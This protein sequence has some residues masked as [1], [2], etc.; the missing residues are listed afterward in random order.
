MTQ[1]KTPGVYVE[2]KNAFGSS[3]VANETAIPIFFG[4]TEKAQ[5]TNGD[6]IPAVTSADGGDEVSMPVLVDSILTYQEH[7]GGEDKTGTMKVTEDNGEF[8]AEI[9]KGTT[10][11][12]PS[13]MYPSISNFFANGGGKCYI[14]SLGN[15]DSFNDIAAIPDMGLFKEAIEYAETA[16][17]I[18]IPD[19]I[20]FGEAKYYDRC[21]ALLNYLEESKRQFLIMDVIQN[22]D[23]NIYS[24]NDAIAFRE[25]VSGAVR[26]GAGYF[27]YLKSLT[28]YAYDKDTTTFNGTLLSVL[29]INGYSYSGEYKNNDEDEIP[30]LVAKYNNKSPTTTPKLTVKGGAT[31]ESS[32]TATGEDKNEVVVTVGTN[33]MTPDD[34]QRKWIK[35]QEGWQLTCLADIT[36]PENEK[37]GTFNEDD[38]WITESDASF[39][40]ILK[41]SGG[42]PKNSTVSANIAAG[43]AFSVAEAN[44]NT[45]T[46]TIETAD[47]NKITAEQ[48]LNKVNTF[49]GQ[50]GN[51]SAAED[52]QFA[53][54]SKFTGQVKGGETATL[55]RV[56]A[57]D[58]ATV[59]KVENFLAQNYIDMPP[60]PFMA[61]IYSR[62]DN[63]QGVWIAPAN[64]SPVGVTA[65]L[66]DITRNQQEGLN[67]DASSGKSI[68]AIR[69]FT[70]RGTL[71]WGARTTDGNSLDWR[72][73]NVRRLFIAME[74]DI[75]KALE[76]YVF[77]PNEHN[78]WVEIK[79]MIEAYLFG[80]FERGAFAGET[81]EQSYQVMIGQGETMSEQDILDG[82]MK[83]S[84]KVAPL[85]PAEF[86]VLTFSQMMA[87]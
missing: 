62:V 61:G 30:V 37:P 54:N 65:P 20:R 74:T 72:Y 71:V 77:K 41:R 24:T 31:E 11:Y 84:I 47:V 56:A 50:S 52:Y 85:R 7:F 25:H 58:N 87:E 28:P 13:Y 8:R 32:V 66:I 33:G 19:L 68:N 14:V 38:P 44:N 67:V 46:I 16:T 83:V 29:S 57:P 75:S 27:P 48:L 78:T 73:I 10:K 15:Y 6:D 49:L 69:S 1:Y 82:F 81:P 2:E 60:S 39:P 34:F 22:S 86:I 55:V 80:L 3:I 79:I 9:K 12:T 21:S 17:L 4:Y 26:Y 23:S 45:L 5:M 18:A 35:D 51:E 64:V 40:L 36:P 59:N 53:V 43:E 76:A 70:G 42:L 63:A